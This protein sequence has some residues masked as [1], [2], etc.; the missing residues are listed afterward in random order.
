MI[1]TKKDQQLSSPREELPKQ[2]ELEIE[3]K[4]GKNKR[5]KERKI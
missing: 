2:T 4:E 5:K 3:F 1:K